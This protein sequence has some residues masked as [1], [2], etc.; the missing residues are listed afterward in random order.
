MNSR[1]YS[2]FDRLLI[3]GK[4][5][6]G[7]IA[8]TLADVYVTD[9]LQVKLDATRAATV[10]KYYVDDVAV[11]TAD[12][13]VQVLGGYGYIREYPVELWLRNARGFATFD[14]MAIV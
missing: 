14:G 2:P 6:G 3:G 12:R 9:R 7:R 13:A 5:M 8:S 11:Q 4:S 1:D 10:M